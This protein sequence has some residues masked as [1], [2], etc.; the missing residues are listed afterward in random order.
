MAKIYINVISRHDGH[1]GMF[2]QFQRAAYF[3]ASKGHECVI[4]PHVGDSL[5]CRA[6]QSSL[7]DFLQT[8]FDYYFT[9]D[10]D[11][12]LPDETFVKLIE[13]DKD[14]IGG[15]YRLKTDYDPSKEEVRNLIATRILPDKPLNLGRDE[16]TEVDYLSTGCIMHKRSFLKDIWDKYS[17]ER[18]YIENR[19]G[20]KIVALYTPMIHPKTRE[21][22][23]EDWAFCYRAQQIGYK[24]YAHCNI[25]CGH[26][27]LKQYSFKEIFDDYGK[28]ENVDVTNASVVN[29]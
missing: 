10:D 25:L 2:T 4:S 9:L 14:F 24:A 13:A 8:D 27:G 20:R 26:W 1:W 16:V 29:T 19:T 22:L 6:R 7:A 15:L 21:Y 23:S 17:K 28:K 12:A 18:W 5:V 3:A 11:I